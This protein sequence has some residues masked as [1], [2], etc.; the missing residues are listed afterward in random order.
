MDGRWLIYM[1]KEL[2]ENK[3]LDEKT[4]LE[5]LF[6][7]FSSCCS[8]LQVEKYLLGAITKNKLPIKVTKIDISRDLETAKKY[9]I[10]T[11]PTLIFCGFMKVH[12]WCDR[13]E[14][15]V[16]VNKFVLTFDL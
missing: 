2:P 14:L 13:A 6:F 8:C 9:D 15:E 3:S 16:L 7:T 4:N 5:I 12:G 10:V 11:C 1:F